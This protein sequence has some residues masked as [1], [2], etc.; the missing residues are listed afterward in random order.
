MKKLGPSEK[1]TINEYG[2]SSFTGK[3]HNTVTPEMIS[4]KWGCGLNTARNTLAGTTQLGV[5]S[6]IG[7]LTRQY[8]TDIPQLHYC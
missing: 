7:P 6:A 3:R 1:P 2:K 5:R 4:K 8:R